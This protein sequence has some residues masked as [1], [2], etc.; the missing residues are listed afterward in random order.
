MVSAA[1]T[2]LAFNALQPK[3]ADLSLGHA[4]EVVFSNQTGD[5]VDFGTYTFYGADADPND[6]CVPGAFAPLKIQPDCAPSQ[7]VLDPTG[8]FSLTSQNPLRANSQCHVAIACPKQF[9]QV[10]SQ[11]AQ[12][13]DII[14][15]ITRLKR[16]G[17]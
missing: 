9:I 2:V 16:T 7:G 13:L 14:A 12:E 11:G 1:G 3:Y 15:V 6:P 17:M 8:T 5:D 4:Y 10:F